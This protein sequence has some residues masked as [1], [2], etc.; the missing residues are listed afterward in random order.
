MRAVV[1]LLVAGGC[2]AAAAEGQVSFIQQVLPILSNNC[3]Q[4]HGASQ[5]LSG[6]DLRSRESMLKGGNHGPAAVP[7]DAQ[8]SRMYRRAAG[9]EEPRMPFGGRLNDAHVA[10]LRDWI[11]QGARWEGVSG[12]PSTAPPHA[13][14]SG[15][16]MEI[17]SEARQYWAF[18]QPVR[19]PV[20]RVKNPEWSRH[21]IDA[22]LM[23]MFEQKGLRPA[24]TADRVTL[25]RRAYLDLLGLPPSPEQVAAFV[26]DTAPNAWEKL[27]DTLLASPHYGERWGRHWLDVARYADRKSTRL[28]SSHIQ[29]SR[30]PSSA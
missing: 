22:F 2:M 8:G 12:A 14:D 28:N 29:K 18:R 25:A 26:S 10:V 13:I 11:N 27:I 23:R 15:I 3:F 20:P 16:D 4:C 24:P 21:P 1:W 19:P 7:G 30:M 9:L 6:L 5:Q 17:P